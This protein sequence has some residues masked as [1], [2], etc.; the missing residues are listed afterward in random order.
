[1][2][3]EQTLAVVVLGV[4]EMIQIQIILVLIQNLQINAKIRIILISHRKK[5]E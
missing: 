2:V 3:R 1:M 4:L 5:E